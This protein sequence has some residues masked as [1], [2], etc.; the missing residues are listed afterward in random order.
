MPWRPVGNAGNSGNRTTSTA[1]IYD[2]NRTGG[3]R[4]KLVTYSVGD[5][6]PRVGHIEDGEIHSL[7]GASMLE[8]IEAAARPDERGSGEDGG[9]G[10]GA[11]PREPGGRGGAPARRRA[12]DA[13][14]EGHH[15]R[16]RGRG[17]GGRQDSGRDAGHGQRARRQPQETR[18]PL[19][20]LR[21]AGGPRDPE[22]SEVRQVRRRVQRRHRGGA[23]RGGQGAQ[24][25]HARP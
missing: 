15:R 13:G 16:G 2:K 25:R 14:G 5:G 20:H 12:G 21:R 17:D 9:A 8:Y 4:L 3:R 6:G 10:R 22:Q 7:G 1:R 19:R 23:G 18:V 24:A 11:P